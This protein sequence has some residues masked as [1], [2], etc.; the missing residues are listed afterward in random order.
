MNQRTFKVFFEDLS[1]FLYLVDFVEA[2]S[3]GFSYAFMIRLYQ[4]LPINVL[5]VFEAFCHKS[6][7]NSVGF[8]VKYEGDRRIATY[9]EGGGIHSLKHSVTFIIWGAV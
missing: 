4:S 7:L 8:L 9:D 5:Q 3:F 1:C 6:F 2:V